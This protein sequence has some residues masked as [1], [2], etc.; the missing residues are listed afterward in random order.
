MAIVYNLVV[1]SSQGGGG[2][3]AQDDRPQ[4]RGYSP[5]GDQ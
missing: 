4:I 3:A 5:L 1:L 2:Q